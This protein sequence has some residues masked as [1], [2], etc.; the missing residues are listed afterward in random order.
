MS[1]QTV[2]EQMLY[3]VHNPSAYLTPDV[4]ADFSGVEISDEGN[5]RVRV[6]GA[7]GTPRPS[8]LKVT[9]AFDGGYLAEAEVSYAGPGAAERASLAADIVKDRIKHVHGIDEPC[10][11]DLIGLNAIHGLEPE[12][13]M[14]VS[15]THL[16]LPTI[17][18]V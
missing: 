14:A 7:K 10:R 11:T 5:D 6:D 1:T 12:T 13:H 8:E 18:L 9:V 4:V 2:K 3:E 15:Y 17:L 16:T